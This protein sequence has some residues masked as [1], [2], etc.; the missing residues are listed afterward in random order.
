M[1]GYENAFVNMLYLFEVYQHH[2]LNMVGNSWS[3]QSFKNNMV[4]R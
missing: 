3:I 1:I 4:Y 2:S